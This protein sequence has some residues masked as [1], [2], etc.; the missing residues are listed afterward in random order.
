[1]ILSELLALYNNFAL[2]YSKIIERAAVEHLSDEVINHYKIF[3]LIKA[4]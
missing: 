1:L 3:I 2:D 4:T